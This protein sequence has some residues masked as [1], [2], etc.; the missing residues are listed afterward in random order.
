M[1]PSTTINRAINQRRDKDVNA[2]QKSEE[3]VYR[4][5]SPEL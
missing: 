5:I 2:L 4:V 3:K 1:L